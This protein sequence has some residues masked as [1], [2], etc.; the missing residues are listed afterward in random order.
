MMIGAEPPALEHHER[1]PGGPVLRVNNLHLPRE[2]Q[3]GVDLDGITLEVRAGEVV[4]IAGVS[5]NGQQELLYALSGEDTRAAA[6]RR[7]RCS[8]RTSAASGR[9][10]GATWGVHF[11][12]EDR[13]G[14]GAVPTLG[15]AHNL[16]LTRTEAISAQRLDRPEGLA[17]A[18]RRASSSASTSRP[19]APMPRPGRCRAAT[20]RSSSSAARS[21]PIP[22]C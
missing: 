8:A 12:P 13:L 2:D 20:C 21:T 1:Q 6:V 19:A 17:A 22:N 4:G 18:G 14:R 7:S 11:V 10:T 9:R 3:F 16:M 5:G 15:L